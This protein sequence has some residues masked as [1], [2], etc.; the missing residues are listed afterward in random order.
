MNRPEHFLAFFSSYWQKIVR[1]LPSLQMSHF[2]SHKRH[3]EAVS[4][5]FNIA[6]SQAFFRELIIYI[7]EG[8]FFILFSSHSFQ[9]REE[10]TSFSRLQAL[11]GES[12]QASAL[13][14]AS[15]H[16]SH[17]SYVKFLFSLTF[18]NSQQPFSRIIQLQALRPLREWVC[19]SL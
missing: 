1:P 4:L 8:I 18:Q 5:L 10:N 2:S 9:S 14:T 6:T 3:W 17:E 7:I 15:L 11:H 12:F 19:A 16:I 13:H